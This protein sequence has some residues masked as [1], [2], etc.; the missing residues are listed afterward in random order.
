V[1][2]E[3]VRIGQPDRGVTVTPHRDLGLVCFEG[4]N[5]KAGSSVFLDAKECEELISAVRDARAE[6][7]RPQEFGEAW[8]W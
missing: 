7:L 6:L 4:R 3:P 8:P 5:R 1:T 2:G